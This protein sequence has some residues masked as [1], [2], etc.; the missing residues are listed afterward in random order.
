MLRS[1]EK[2]NRKDNKIIVAPELEVFYYIGISIG[3]QREL[4]FLWRIS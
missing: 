2:E 3:L 4:N 1:R